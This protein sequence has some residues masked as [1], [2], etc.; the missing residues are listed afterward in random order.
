[1]DWTASLRRPLSR[2]L[3]TI[4]VIAVAANA[5]LN[6]NEGEATQF[7][8]QLDPI[9]LKEANAQMTTRWQYITDVTDEHSQAQVSLHPTLVI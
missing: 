1:M 7:L 9:Y 6:A 2:F 8:E 5:Q 4:L 3:V